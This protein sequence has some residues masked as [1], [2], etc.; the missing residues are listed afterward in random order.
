LLC[1]PDVDN[2]EPVPK[3][4]KTKG[5]TILFVGNTGNGTIVKVDTAGNVSSFASVENPFGLAFDTAGFLYAADFND[6]TIR[7][8]DPNGNVSVFARGLGAP[9]DIIFDRSGNLYVALSAGSVIKITPGGKQSLFAT[10]FSAINTSGLA[11]DLSGNL[12][13]SSVGGN[14]IGDGVIDK[15]TPNGTVSTFVTGLSGPL[16]IATNA[17]GELYE[18]DRNTQSIKKISA[19]GAVSTFA[20]GLYNAHGLAF[21]PD[22]TLYV[23]Q[24]AN[25][26]QK[27]SPAGVV[28]FF[29]PRMDSA[30]FIAVQTVKGHR[31]LTG[32]SRRR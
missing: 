10:G 5:K 13:V 9:R 12:F 8:I 29:G 20:T 2:E 1:S 22:G 26:L 25:R 11:F 14:T 31:R 28:S 15:V 23:T 21:A 17:A 27:V 7:K 6:G 3:P 16:D 18:A 24:G 30:N 19:R 4:H 32:A